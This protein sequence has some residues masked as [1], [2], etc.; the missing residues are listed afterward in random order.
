MLATIDGGLPKASSPKRV[1]VVGA[2]MA[3]LVAAYEL[4]RAGHDITLMEASRRIGGR[5]WT[6][7]DPHFTHGL[8]AEGGAMRIP[9]AHELTWRY[10]NRFELETQPFIMKRKNQILMIANKRM[11]WAQFECNPTV[12]GLKLAMNEVGRTPRDLWNET[13]RPL[14]SRFAEGGW[15]EILQ[16]W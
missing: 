14:R 8:Y 13:V 9:D 6:L 1:I 12:P 5:V 2:G 3:G 10:I 16:E 15:A 11:T 7:R 4:K